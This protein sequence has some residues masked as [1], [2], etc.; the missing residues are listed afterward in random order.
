MFTALLLAALALAVWEVWLAWRRVRRGEPLKR[1]DRLLRRLL[2][3]VLPPLV[4]ACSISRPRVFTGL[5]HAFVAWGFFSYALGFLGHIFSAWG[6]ELPALAWPPDLLSAPVLV[7]VVYLFVRRAFARPEHLRPPEREGI[8]VKINFGHVNLESC[9]ILLL[10]S[11]IVITQLLWEAWGGVPAPV[12]RALSS[13]LGE[14][15][16]LSQAAWWLHVL[17]V[18]GFMVWLPRTKHIHLLWGPVNR[19]FTNTGLEPTGVV[20]KLEL[21]DESLDHFGAVLVKHLPWK[22]LSDGYACVECGRC[23]EVCPAY[24]TGKPLSPRAIM[25]NL[26]V[27][28]VEGEIFK[29]VLTA[30]SAWTCTTC[31][32]CLHVCPVGALRPG[33]PFDRFRCYYRN[34][35]LSE[36]CGFLCMRVCPYGAEYEC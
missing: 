6:L 32:A 9:V 35:W 19:F 1:N 16:S 30:G 13:L 23:Q 28:P 10:I 24:A 18:L 4:Q 8:L 31:G 14:N 15:P 3:A 21:E 11:G 25:E 5:M 12:G 7:G 2:N 27:A 22:S 34:R 29:E 36:P 17:L 33:K 26:K 20:R